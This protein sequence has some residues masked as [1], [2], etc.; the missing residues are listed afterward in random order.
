[1][2]LTDYIQK[3]PFFLAPMAG[4]TDQPFRSFMKE[5]GCGIITTELVSAKGLQ[6]GSS[7]SHK[8]FSYSES[9]KPVGIQIFGEDIDAIAYTV[10]YLEQEAQ[11][12]F[13]DLNLGCPVNKIVKKG[14][15]S[16][17]LK[18]LTTLTLILKAMRKNC[19]LPLSLKVRT[20]W[21]QQSLNADQVARIAYEEGF[22]W[23]TIHGRT[24]AQGYSGQADWEYIKKIKAS[25]PI[26]IIGNGD[27]NSATKAVDA[28]KWSGCDGIMIGRGCL[29]D[30]WIFQDSLCLLS[31]KE[32]NKNKNFIHIITNFKNHLE[33]FY[34]G[35]L[36]LLQLKKISAWFSAG[37]PNSSEFRQQVFQEKEKSSVLNKIEDYF[38][39]YENFQKKNP[40]YE[41]F[42]MQ[43][44]G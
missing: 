16:A 39:M 14:A 11:P 13:I 33:N 3:N 19:T 44:H 12:D 8:L 24:R 2:S 34:D 28:L 29:N 38:G 15:G 35:P 41:P 30:P 20:G 27:I 40:K 1:M 43:G 26:P 23:M 7:K 4:V 42:L 6:Q 21:D 22:S 31:E 5:M 18:D 36:F 25:S 32:I 10:A 37:L 17:L 9:Q